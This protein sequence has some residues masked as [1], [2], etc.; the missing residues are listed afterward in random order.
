MEC[1]DC[2]KQGFK[3]LF[4]F[5]EETEI[6]IN[7][8]IILVYMGIYGYA[9]CMQTPI[10]EDESEEFDLGKLSNKN[11]NTYKKLTSEIEST[12]KKLNDLEEKL[13]RS[14]PE[15]GTSKDAKEK[16]KPTVSTT[17]EAADL[18]E[19][20]KNATSK[21]EDTVN[22]AAKKADEKT[23]TDPSKTKKTTKR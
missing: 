1:L 12:K 9:Y 23:A 21:V 19:A 10:E 5:E 16:L 4:N 3:Q 14:F 11:K 2:F 20:A 17:Q 13:A 22:K 6:M 7:S 8:G 18:D 15:A